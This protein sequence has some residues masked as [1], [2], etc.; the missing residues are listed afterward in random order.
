MPAGKYKKS[1][2]IVLYFNAGFRL[3]LHTDD[4]IKIPGMGLE[5]ETAEVSEM[6]DLTNRDYIP[7][8]DLDG[9]DANA[10][11]KDK[12]VPYSKPIPRN[13]QA[14][15]ND[16]GKP[17]DGGDTSREIKDVITQ[18]ESNPDRSSLP[19]AMVV[20]GRRVAILRE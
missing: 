15:W 17:D 9:A 20:S 10:D 12:K 7:G 8:L 19:T 6:V 1:R 13:F 5:A 3:Y 16:T 4:H 2:I 11:R 14:Q 18:L